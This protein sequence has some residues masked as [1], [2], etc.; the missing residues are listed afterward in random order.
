MD[1]WT[2]TDLLHRVAR[3]WIPEVVGAGLAVATVVVG[4]RVVHAVS[5]IESAQAVGW[6][7]G[8]PW[9]GFLDVE[10]Q[11]SPSGPGI[12]IDSVIPGGASQGLLSRG[13]VI[14]AID[15][16]AT[17]TMAQLSG[18]LWNTTPG[19]VVQLTVL[20]SGVQSATSKASVTV[21]LGDNPDFAQPFGTGPSR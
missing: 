21:R 13:D 17:P 10:V 8:P 11:Q 19:E 3:S 2:R 14:M 16:H 7:D 20:R 5:R 1:D 18:Q 9:R 4:P 12:L 6:L 15:G